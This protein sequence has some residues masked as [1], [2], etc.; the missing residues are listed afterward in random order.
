MDS[1]MSSLTALAERVEQVEAAKRDVVAQTRAVR[2]VDDDHIAFDGGPE[3]AVT[4]HAHGQIAARLRIPKPYYDRVGAE[5]PGLRQQMLER[6]FRDG[7]ERRMFRLVRDLGNG[8]PDE[9]S[10]NSLRAFLSDRYRPMDHGYMLSALLPAIEEVEARS[11]IGVRIVSQS[12]TTSRMY[13]QLTFP[14][15]QVEVVRGDVIEAG[16]TAVNSE[17]GAGAYDFLEWVRRLICSNGMVG[18]SIVR[19]Y[20]AGRRIGEDDDDYVVFRDDTVKADLEALRLRARDMLVAAASEATLEA[21]AQKM[22]AAAEDFAEVKVPQLVE[23]VTRHFGLSEAEAEH[24]TGAL[25]QDEHG[26]TRYG[27]LNSITALAHKLDDR[28]RQWEVER[29]GQQVL[30]MKPATWRELAAT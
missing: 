2:V 29:M 3:Y 13:L 8:A 16:V 27:L 1:N 19:R 10:G 11:G 5:F 24:V 15:V 7:S 9:L 22:R 21:K 12:V 25:Y 30:D 26:R 20:H 23:N 14:G 28:N 4:P 18:E 17:V 6:H